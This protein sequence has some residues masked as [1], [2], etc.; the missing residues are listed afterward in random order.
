MNGLANPNGIHTGVEMTG[1]G[2]GMCTVGQLRQESAGGSNGSAPRRHRK[3]RKVHDLKM[4]IW[5]WSAGTGLKSR[6]ADLPSRGEVHYR[7]V[8]TVGY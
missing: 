8:I 5:R 1:D 2:P 6:T 3:D 7:R 4:S